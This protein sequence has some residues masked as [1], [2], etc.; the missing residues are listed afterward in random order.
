MASRKKRCLMNPL[1]EKYDKYDILLLCETWLR[2]ENTNNLR[3]PNGYLYKF[4]SKIRGEKK[5]V[6]QEG[7]W[8]GIVYFRN[9]LNK[10]ASVFDK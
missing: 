9:E 4:V 2:R 10:A 7:A 8:V 3:H 1:S 5:A 6:H